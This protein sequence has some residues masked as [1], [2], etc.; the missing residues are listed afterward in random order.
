MEMAKKE[1]VPGLVAAFLLLA[2]PLSAHAW[3]PNARNLDRAIR[4]GDFKKYAANLSKWLNQKTPSDPSRLSKDKLKALLDEP[5]FAKALAQRQ[6]IVKVGADKLAGFAAH[7][8]NRDFLAWV[9]GSTEAMTHC[10]EGA[11]P[12]P[13]KH[14]RADNWKIPG[15]TLAIWKKIYDA[16]PDSKEGVCLKLAIAVGMNPPGTG[17]RGAGQAKK[18]EKPL[19]RYKHFKAAYENDELA[20]GFEDHSVWG[21]R[22]IVSSNASNEDL[23]WAREMINTWRPDLR[24][25]EDVVSSTSEVWYRN[26]PVPFNHSFKNVLAGGGKC[27]PRSS[28]AVFICQAFGIPAV[29]VRQPG[30]ACAAFKAYNISI[31]PQPGFAWKVVYGRGWGAS[32][33]GQ[34]FF[35]GATLRTNLSRFMQVERLRWLASALKSNARTAV[36]KL[37]HNMTEK[38]RKEAMAGPGVDTT[39]FKTAAHKT[40]ALSSFEA[41]RHVGDMYTTRVR[42]FVYPPRTGEYVFSIV[43]DDA[44]DLFLSTDEKPEN[45]KRLAYVRKWTAARQFNAQP[46]QKSEPVRLKAGKRYYIEAIHREHTGGD[47]LAV[48]WS[49]PGFDRKIIQGKY[50]SPY[51]NG[52]K[53]TIGRKVWYDV[54]P[55]PPVAPTEKPHLVRETGTLRIPADAFSKR[56]QV[57]VLDSYADDGKQIHFDAN[58]DHRFVEYTLNVRKAGDYALKMQTA[59][60]N[61]HQM[62]NINVDEKKVATVKVPNSHGLWTTTEEAD[63]PLVR[64]TQTL[65]VYAPFQRGVALKWLELKAKGDGQ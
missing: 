46:T 34:G 11:T 65:R 35:E 37:A 12:V 3:A 23:A 28:W 8:S 54:K 45:K 26:S 21:Y 51:P 53:G 10:L 57:R 4:A 6:F 29:G 33:P 27:G 63:I 32:N 9:L 13:I 38:D 17:N 59:A 64:G 56:Q 39:P 7:T 22:Q 61:F 60:V 55:T 48:A 41:P 31:L 36:I 14:R 58:S 16:D 19:D 40:S 52:K 44:S 42:G 50:L 25:H 30:H 47:H 62:F 1:M 20:R 5:A 49:G 2:L 43:S 18:P 15:K 24:V